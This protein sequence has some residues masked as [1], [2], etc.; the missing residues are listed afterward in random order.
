M[1]RIE[2]VK[3]ILNQ[4]RT[5]GFGGV[6]YA[7]DEDSIEETARQICQLFPQPLTDEGLREK[8]QNVVAF[9]I[10]N[11]RFGFGDITQED[12]N[13]LTECDKQSIWQNAE[14]LSSQIL[15]LL[16]QRVEQERERIKR[17]FIKYLTVDSE[18]QDAR[19]KEFNQA[20]FNAKEGWAVFCGTDLAMVMEKLDKALSDN[21]EGE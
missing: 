5:E 7:L 13:G 21:K 8:I 10:A 1:K 4:Q 15:A 9:W 20:I 11:E 6:E 18:T 3:K 2:E 16:Q 12:W 17:S 14:V 19:R